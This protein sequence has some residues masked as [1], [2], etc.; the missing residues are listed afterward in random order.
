M[1]TSLPF[2]PLS[3]AE[4][5]IISWAIG[6]PPAKNQKKKTIFGK[7]IINIIIDC[8]QTFNCIFLKVHL[9]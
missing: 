8:L 5:S 7:L 6:N 3:S 9:S 1:T 2:A 4:L